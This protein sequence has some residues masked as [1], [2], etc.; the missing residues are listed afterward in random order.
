MPEEIIQVEH[1]CQT[2]PAL[3]ATPRRGRRGSRHSRPPPPGGR[4]RSEA[5]LVRRVP[6]PPEGRAQDRRRARPSRRGSIGPGERGA[7]AD[8]RRRGRAPGVHEHVVDE[9]DG[10]VEGRQRG[11]VDVE[12]VDQALGVVAHGSRSR[13]ATASAEVAC[14]RSGCADRRAGRRVEPQQRRPRLRLGRRRARTWIAPGASSTTRP[15]RLE[16]GDERGDR[17]SVREAC[18]PGEKLASA[19]RATADPP[20]GVSTTRSRLRSSRRPSERPSRRH[21][22]RNS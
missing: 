5:R 15:R 18:L 20:Q 3:Q 4:D 2:S 12:V 14:G 8:R 16:V 21:R 19:R 7:D 11:M 10:R 13:S 9:L 1:V 6:G 22:G 17:S